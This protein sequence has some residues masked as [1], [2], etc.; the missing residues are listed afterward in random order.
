MVR[1]HAPLHV[2]SGFDIDLDAV[3]AWMCIADAKGTPASQ[4]AWFGNGRRVVRG[5]PREAYDWWNTVDGV[6]CVNQWM[7]GKHDDLDLSLDRFDRLETRLGIGGVDFVFAP[8]RTAS[9]VQIVHP[10]PAPGPVVADIGEAVSALARSLDGAPLR[11]DG[12]DAGAGAWFGTQ[13]ESGRDG[14]RGPARVTTRTKV[15]VVDQPPLPWTSLKRKPST[16]VS[17]ISTF[18]PCASTRITPSPVLGPERTLTEVVVTRVPM[19]GPASP[20]MWEP[21]VK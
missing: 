3:R 2:V 21:S 5:F 1:F 10:R 4:D 9:L 20:G 18:V 14:E 6:H 19:T 16:T 17:V 11:H 8:P 15:V 12:Q 7:R 13:I